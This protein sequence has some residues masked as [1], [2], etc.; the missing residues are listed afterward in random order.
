MAYNRIMIFIETAIFTREI[1]KLLPDG[2][3]HGLQM[4]LLLRPDA[5][6]L[7]RGSGGLRKI[8]WSM[9]GAGK[10]GGLR[11]IYYWDMPDK[12]YMLLPYKKSAQEDL[13]PAQL[14]TLTNLIKEWI[15]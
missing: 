13:T 3:Y 14:K 12:I 4:S 6:E 11:I 7:I 9:P 1:N 2:E 8:R 10:R 5:G 15:K